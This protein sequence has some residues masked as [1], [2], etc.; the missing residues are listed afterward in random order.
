MP[1]STIT[2]RN[3]ILCEM[4]NYILNEI[5]D[6]EIFDIWL[7]CGVPDGATIDDILEIAKDDDLWLDC[8]ECFA[9]C[10]KLAGVIE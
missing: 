5:G 2:L 9:K 6:E 8:V 4:N 10:C 1:K 7:M 3:L